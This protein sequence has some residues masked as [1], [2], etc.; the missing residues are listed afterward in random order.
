[1][2]QRVATDDYKDALTC[3]TLRLLHKLGDEATTY[4][5]E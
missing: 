3:T 5:L 2:H 4:P 1:M